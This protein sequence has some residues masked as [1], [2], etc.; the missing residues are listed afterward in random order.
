MASVSLC[1]WSIAM[2]HGIACSA[3]PYPISH[4]REPGCSATSAR[5]HLYARSNR[6]LMLFCGRLVLHNAAVLRRRNAAARQRLCTP[7]AT[8]SDRNGLVRQLTSQTTLRFISFACDVR[9]ACT[10]NAQRADSVIKMSWLGNQAACTARNVPC[11]YG[12]S[13]YTCNKGSS[14]VSLCYAAPCSALNRRANA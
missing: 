13:M 10:E 14:R 12:T 11:Q 5:E 9:R 2:Y 1:M 7:S 4:A 3:G 8:E 6:K